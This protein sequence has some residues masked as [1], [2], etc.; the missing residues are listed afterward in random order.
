M[1]T[2]LRRVASTNYSELFPSQICT[3]TLTFWVDYGDPTWHF[4]KNRRFVVI[5]TTVSLG[6]CFQSFQVFVH[7]SGR[8][9]FTAFF[10]DF[11]HEDVIG[12]SAG[13]VRIN[14]VVVA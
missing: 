11:P 9:K 13:D 1:Q 14:R 7:A 5:I 8:A 3:R 4:N 10:W 6:H 2:D 12:N